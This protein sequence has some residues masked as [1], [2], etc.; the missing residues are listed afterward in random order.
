MAPS[1]RRFDPPARSLLAG[2]PTDTQSLPSTEMYCGS[3]RCVVWASYGLFIDARLHGWVLDPRG[4]RQCILAAPPAD[5]TENDF[6]RAARIDHQQ[7]NRRQPA[8][9]LVVL[10]E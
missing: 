7:G 8:F 1:K 10:R 3:A 9:L 2:A 5:P 4:F 6:R